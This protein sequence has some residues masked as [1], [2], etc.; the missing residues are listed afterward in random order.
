MSA[1][2]IFVTTLDTLTITLDNLQ[3]PMHAAGQLLSDLQFAFGRTLTGATTL[4]SSSGEEIS[5]SGGIGTTGSTVSTGWGFG[6][7]GSGFSLAFHGPSHTIIGPG[8]YT[9]ANPSI[10]DGGPHNPFIDETATFTISNSSIT[11]STTI[12]SA[13]FSFGTEAGDNVTGC[14]DG[15]TNCG[16]TVIG[17][18]SPEP[19]SMFLMGAGL[20]GI[21]VLR[22]F[23]RG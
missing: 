8:P 11:T 16:A 5:I 4:T 14:V 13:V 23:R 17:G 10:G 22:K 7:D 15:S 1:E 6:T 12:S 3:S 2:A 21:G 19:L 9:S 18:D 20:L